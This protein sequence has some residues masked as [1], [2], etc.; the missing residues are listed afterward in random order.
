LVSFTQEEANKLIEI[1]NQISELENKKK[2]L[3]EKLGA[4]MLENNL[5]ITEFKNFIVKYVPPSYTFSIDFKRIEAED[6]KLY[7]EISSRFERKINKVGFVKIS[8]F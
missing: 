1:E 5:E 3:R 7:S 2:E 6:P 8:K 4:Y